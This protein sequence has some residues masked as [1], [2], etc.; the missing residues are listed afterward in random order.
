MNLMKALLSS[1]A[2]TQ[3]TQIQPTKGTVDKVF[4]KAGAVSRQ[5]GFQ[6]P[7]SLHVTTDMLTGPI[8]GATNPDAFITISGI[9]P[10]TPIVGQVAST[11]GSNAP[12][13]GNC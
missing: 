10:T 13:G 2:V 5:P 7:A 4:F 8:W 11:L 9:P 1:R 6:D 12:V 3:L